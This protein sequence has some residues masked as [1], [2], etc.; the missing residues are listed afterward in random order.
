[1]LV[2]TRAPGQAVRIGAD[3][4]VTVVAV[5]GRTV[6]LGIEAP[7]AVAVYREELYQRLTA[8]NREAAASAPGAVAAS[9]AALGAGPASDPP[10]P[11]A[12]CSAR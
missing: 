10:P 9:A 1:M 4:T 7:P 8:L 11:C 12:S 6:R 2:L 5:R 3:V